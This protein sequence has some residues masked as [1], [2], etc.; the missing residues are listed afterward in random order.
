MSGQLST[1]RQFLKTGSLAALHL[2]L[3]LASVV[4]ATSQLAWAE[5]PVNFPAPGGKNERQW[6]IQGV[7]FSPDGSLVAVGT[8]LDTS[9]PQPVSVEMWDVRTGQRRGTLSGHPNGIKS[10][11][12]SA[13]GKLI[14]SA[15]NLD[16]IKLWQSETLTEI[17]SISPTAMIT[18]LSFSPDEKFLVAGLD[19]F[20]VRKGQNSAE[21][22]D[23]ATQKLVRRFMGH[24]AGVSA[25][26]FSPNGTV[27]AT[28]SSDGTARLW[29]VASGKS[30]A[31]LTDQQLHRTLQDYYRRTSG[32]DDSGL[33]PSTTSI[34]FSPDGRRLAVAG[35]TTI[36]RGRE[37]GIGA[38]TLWDAETHQ[39]QGMLSGC[40]STVQQLAFSVDGKLLAAAGRDG[41]VRIWDANIL[42]QVARFQG[43]APMAFSPDG[44]S[45]IS[46]TSE[47]AIVLRQLADVTAQ[48]VSEEGVSGKLVGLEQLWAVG[49][50][51]LAPNYDNYLSTAFDP[52]SKAILGL[53]YRQCDVLGL[54][55]KVRRSFPM[56]VHVD[57]L[58]SARLG[59]AADGEF[60]GFRKPW[61]DAVVA[62]N[63]AGKVL[64][65]QT[66]AD[67]LDD[68][69]AADLDGDG[70]DEVIAGYNGKGG[71][72]VFDHAGMRRWKNT[73]LTNVWSVAAGNILGAEKKQVIAPAKTRNVEIFDADGRS[74]K[75]LDAPVN[76]QM[77]RAV[78][79]AKN[80]ASDVILIA[81]AAD[82]G[83]SAIAALDG[84]G[85]LLWFEHDRKKYQQVDSM[86][87]CPNRPWVAISG[88]GINSSGPVTVVDCRTGKIIGDAGNQ[89]NRA[90]VAWAVSE[91]GDTPILLVASIRALSA[92][93]VKAGRSD[94]NSEK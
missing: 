15:G 17:G 44:K 83:D 82:V 5:E 14:A 75:L 19:A 9:V 53:H 61:G 27:L 77:V 85:K 88:G 22:Y 51:Y 29:D 40:D 57:T 18:S 87:V 63:S 54:D 74:I 25:V 59:D 64:W 4:L 28:G 35:G 66:S 24:T 84:N 69:W 46:T 21:L 11:A 76:V 52:R 43:S 62:F 26:A 71:L 2:R 49:H 41:Q 79:L 56:E 33:P 55:G 20:L 80:D 34:T 93:R 86:A 32:R 47:M 31:T 67:G 48:G 16:A 12:F 1:R 45:L 60:I 89:G 78:R 58:R 8:F 91:D 94:E 50:E 81:G 13:T 42:R 10:V 39:P 70:R 72:H 36:A 92:F 3:V 90:Q 23:A 37:F 73:D 68:V 6:A 7:A 65:Q 30:I 38:V